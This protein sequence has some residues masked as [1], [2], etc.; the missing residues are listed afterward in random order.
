M[1]VVGGVS[2]G[3]RSLC[4][5]LLLDFVFFAFAVASLYGKGNCLTIC[6][7]KVV[8]NGTHVMGHG[9]VTAFVDNVA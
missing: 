9:R 7:T 2:L 5:V 4:P 6:V 3:G 8:I 1:T